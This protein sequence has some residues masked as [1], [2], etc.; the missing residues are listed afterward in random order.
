MYPGYICGRNRIATLLRSSR[1][2]ANPRASCRTHACVHIYTDEI[3]LLRCFAAPAILPTLELPVARMHAYIS[4]RMRSD[5]Y[6]ASQLPQSCQP[7][8]SAL[9][10][11]SLGLSCPISSLSHACKHARQE[12]R[13]L[14]H[15]MLPFISRRI[16]LFISTAYSSG[17]SLDTVSANPL[18][19][20]AL[21]SSS[22]TPRDIR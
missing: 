8:S 2:P 3:G 14:S 5:C 15:P 20:I 7:S 10:R 17:S 13:G 19:I 6:A 11:F 1:N 9:S 21:A 22:D 4:I 12:L 18:T 16:R